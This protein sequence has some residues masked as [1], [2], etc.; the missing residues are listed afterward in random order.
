MLFASDQAIIFR[1]CV[2][3]LLIL[4]LTQPGFRNYPTLTNTAEI[5]PIVFRSM[6]IGLFFTFQNLCQRT[7]CNLLRLFP[8]QAAQAA[9]GRRGTL[10]PGPADKKN[11]EIEFAQY[12][13]AF[14]RLVASFALRPR[15]EGA[16]WMVG[17][18]SAAG[19]CCCVS[20]AD[21]GQRA[22]SCSPRS[23][24]RCRLDTGARGSGAWPERGSE[25]GLKRG[26]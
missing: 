23:R 8:A 10:K 13:S 19:R 21:L 12:S 24:L 9:G 6:F 25:P 15:G 20:G 4:A 16:N 7:F 22:A 1:T 3:C 14:Q 11:D 2:L 5:A 26:L 17:E 18:K